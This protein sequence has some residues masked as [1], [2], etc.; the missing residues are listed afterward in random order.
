MSEL[1]AEEHEA[2]TNEYK[3][4]RQDVAKLIDLACGCAV[5][6]DRKGGEM[7]KYIDKVLL[8]AVAQ[9]QRTGASCG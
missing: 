3:A 5:Q 2:I 9:W 4:V 6:R 7:I 8:A 1:S